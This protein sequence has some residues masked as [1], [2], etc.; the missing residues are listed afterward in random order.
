MAFISYCFL[1]LLSTNYKYT[2]PCYFPLLPKTCRSEAREEVEFFDD[3]FYAC[4][5]PVAFS[6]DY[7]TFRYFAFVRVF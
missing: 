4:V 3:E 2:H 6:M 5:A 7:R 1:H